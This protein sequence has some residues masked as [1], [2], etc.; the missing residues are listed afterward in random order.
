[1]R[2]HK[3]ALLSLMVLII[4]SLVWLPSRQ[5]QELRPSEVARL[6]IKNGSNQ[7]S[8]LLEL[9]SSDNEL[10]R[11]LGLFLPLEPYGKPTEGIESFGE[12]KLY[13]HDGGV[14]KYSILSDGEYAILTKEG[15][16]YH[17]WE[18]TRFSDFSEPTPA[19]PHPF[20]DRTPI[21][22]RINGEFII[23]DALVEYKTEIKGRKVDEFIKLLGPFAERAIQNASL[24]SHGLI[25]LYFK[26]G[27]IVQGLILS[28]DDSLTFSFNGIQYDSGSLMKLTSFLEQ[29]K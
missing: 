8:I 13:Y 16:A 15:R 11:F 12:M 6:E 7:D 9:K 23:E 2:I 24:I 3:I 4:A 20:T 18:W 21:L 22:I 17:G 5:K 10:S 25:T 19:P 28:Y 27:M 29:S 26:E 1:M 14:G